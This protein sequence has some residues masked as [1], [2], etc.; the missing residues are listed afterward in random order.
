MMST[1]LVEALT[2]GGERFRD[3]RDAGRQ[4][5]ERLRSLD[6]TDAVVVGLP[7]GGVPV[8]FEV[9]TALGA[10]LDVLVVRKI[11]SPGNPE[12]GMG[13]VAEGG[14]RVFN[15]EVIATVLASPEELEH[16][17]ERAERELEERVRRYRRGRPAVGLVDRTV[18]LVDD[19][20]ATGGTA[21]AAARAIRARGPRRLVLAVP[22]GAPE[23]IEKLQP[24][25][26]EIVC[27]C[28]PPLLWAIGAWYEDFTQTSDQE[29]DDLLARAQAAPA[30][31]AAAAGPAT[32]RRG[33]VSAD[34]AGR[35]EVRIA[36]PGGAE[37]VGDLVTPAHARGI[38]VFA[39]GSGSSRHSPRN[40][41]VA[42]AL[43]EAALATLLIDLLTVEE[44][45]HRAN[46][47]DI[48]LL[49]GRLV[50]ATRW[51]RAHAE[52]AG[53]AV[54]YFGASTGAGAA[55][56]AAADLG[57]EIGAVVSRGGRPDLAAPRLAEVRAP[58]LLIVGGL[59]S[60][61]IDLN[62]QALAELRCDAALEIVPGATH[63]FEEPGTL[64]AVQDLAAGWFSRHLAAAATAAPA[65]PR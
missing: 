57:D 39:H 62:R 29:V 53:L 44:E 41:Q 12:L 7:R 58:T 21:R 49:A 28:A 10:P 17:A 59:D 64:D 19:G 60:V 55:L 18:V 5:A 6:V 8:A 56:W 32:P 38:V 47:F 40:R 45:R 35:R 1:N 50:A 22:V 26:D 42:S 2:G 48:G 61:V 33:G 52:L 63:L 16:A 46:V 51:V 11:G 30:E 31:Q 36:L 24:E 25:F 54:G 3:R 15:E 4:L 27:L 65:R 13:A 43:N 20:L 34:P 37:I 23:T 9:A 14:L